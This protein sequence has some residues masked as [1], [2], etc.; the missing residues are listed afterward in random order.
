[1]VDTIRE[2]ELVYH[3]GTSNKIYKLKMLK[4]GNNT[5]S[6]YGLFGKRWAY[7]LNRT[8][9]CIR[10]SLNDAN[11]MYDKVLNEKFRKGYQEV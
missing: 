7:N 6:V 10:V 2:D 5:F 8:D 11:K 9:K 4:H 3:S 1:M